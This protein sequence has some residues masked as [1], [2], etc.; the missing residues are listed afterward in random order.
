MLNKPEVG[1][2]L[3]EKVIAYTKCYIYVTQCNIHKPHFSN[4][5]QYLD[6][7]SKLE[8]PFVEILRI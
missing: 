4:L 7:I 2:I 6:S 3:E 5:K 8:I 1:C